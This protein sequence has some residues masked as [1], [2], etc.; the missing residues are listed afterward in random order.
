MQSEP[1]HASL[2]LAT[3]QVMAGN[4]H[5]RETFGLRSRRAALLALERAILRHRGDIRAALAADLGRDPAET[6]LVDILPVLAEI[7]HAR[8]HLWRWMVGRPVWPS[9]AVLGTWASVRPEPK[10]TVL[11][12]APWNFPLMLCLSPLASALA[13]G[14]G[15][16]IKPSEYTPRTADVI[17]RIVD[18]ALPADLVQVVEGGAEVAQ[19]LLAQPFDHIFFTGSPPVGRSVMQAAAQNLTPVTLE[20]GGKSPVI[21]DE[22]ADLVQA[23]RWIAWGKL[24][25]GGQV[26]VG[27]DH[28]FVHQ[29]RLDAFRAALTDAFAALRSGAA[30]GARIAHARH[31]A[32]LMALVSDAAENG[33]KV[34]ALGADDPETLHI[35]PR[36]IEGQTE[37]MQIATEEIFGPLL[38]ILPFDE[39]GQVITQINAG[40]KPLALY[41]F[42]KDRKTVSR[43]RG[44]T[45]SGS[46]GVN[47]TLVPF[48]HGNL[49]FGGIGQSGMGATHGRAGFMAFSHLKPVVRR[50]LSP[51]P[52]VF[53]PYTRGVRRLIGWMIRLF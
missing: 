1:I 32:R 48:V 18:T 7:R 4:A 38:P 3:K 31:Y 35:A 34:T 33:G 29:S 9:R 21:V 42:S 20:L 5:R 2:T 23:A 44:Q 8:R 11:I 22:T 13:S 45:S 6:D 51:L 36:L 30:K 28:V 27:P 16:V 24:V 46:V 19:T 41:V 47:L 50:G 52:M 43:V 26:C 39:L 12:L 10:G 15:A 53:P 17:R 37:T 14:N 49:P 40:P 25:N